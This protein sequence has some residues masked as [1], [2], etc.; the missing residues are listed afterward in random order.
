M[1]ETG[2]SVNRMA[3]DVRRLANYN[4]T[5]P[6]A[7]P[8]ESVRLLRAFDHYSHLESITDGR[9]LQAVYRELFGLKN[10]LTIINNLTIPTIESPSVKDNYMMLY[11]DANAAP[12]SP[13]ASFVYREEL[14]LDDL[15]MDANHR[16]TNTNVSSEILSRNG[17]NQLL[18]SIS[19]LNNE[20]DDAE[21]NQSSAPADSIKQLQT[22]NLLRALMFYSG[23]RVRWIL[24]SWLMA[25]R[26]KRLTAYRSLQMLHNALNRHWFPSAAG[27]RLMIFKRRFQLSDCLH[28][29]ICQHRFRCLNGDM[30]IDVQHILLHRWLLN[31]RLAFYYR[32]NIGKLRSIF[33]VNNLIIF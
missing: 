14:R 6:P 12:S 10:L 4:S 22:E 21:R 27:R 7:D 8:L 5:V 25:V 30:E 28:K 33:Q 23:C 1:D 19:S 24:K 17:E 16:H 31:C 11:P 18:C 26:L 29:W 2:G 15:T 9:L 32:L 3:S 20:E 13:L